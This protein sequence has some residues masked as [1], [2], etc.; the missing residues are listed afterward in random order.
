MRSDALTEYSLRQMW[1]QAEQLVASNKLKEALKL[2][3]THY[4][5]PSLPAE[6]REAIV[7]W[8][9]PLAAKVIYSREHILE[10]PYRTRAKETLFDVEERFNVPWQLLHNINRE[11]VS[12]PQLVIVGT[13]LKVVQGPFRAEVHL[14]RNELTLYL[15]D[16]YAGR[17]GFTLGN[18]PPQPGSY[19]VVDKRRDRVYYGA[20][21]TTIP[22]G[23]PNNP[24]GDI[25]L[26]L[27]REVSIHGS[28][29]QASGTTLG[30]IS[31]SP[32]DS[33]DVYGILSLGSEVVI[34]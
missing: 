15:G 13:E 27:G 8:L 16:L 5:N 19:K 6:H 9:D 33:R 30:C 29:A 18:E 22:A 10:L 25:W 17:F 32:Q 34:R 7:G 11:V 14:S 23:D 28:P 1:S 31:L 26:D 3:S 24:Y 21:G 4:S 2:L 12:D 20:D